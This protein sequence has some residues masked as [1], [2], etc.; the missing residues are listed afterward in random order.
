MS[1]LKSSPDLLI[2]FGLGRMFVMVIRDH[3]GFVNPRTLSIFHLICELKVQDCEFFRIHVIGWVCCDSGVC[4]IH[5]HSL[6]ISSSIKFKC[7]Y[8]IKYSIKC[9]YRVHSCKRLFKST[10]GIVFFFPG[11]CQKEFRLTLSSKSFLIFERNQI[12]HFVLLSDLC[13]TLYSSSI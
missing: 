8:N 12:H 1:V 7:T 9:V 10:T 13:Y 3:F 4:V 2:T 6:Y 5:F 11:E